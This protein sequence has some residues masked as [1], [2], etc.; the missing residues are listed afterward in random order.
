VSDHIKFCLAVLIYHC[1]NIPTYL[2][3]DLH[4]AATRTLIDDFGHYHHQVVGAGTRLNT[5][6]LCSCCQC[7]P[8]LSSLNSV[9]SS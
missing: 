9:V 2:A 6:W 8:P 5:S 7:H 3:R 4:W 1:N